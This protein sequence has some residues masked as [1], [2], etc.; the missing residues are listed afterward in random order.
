MVDVFDEVEEELRQERYNDLLKKWGPWVGGVA[1][2][3]VLGVGAYQFMEWSTK[4]R[5]DAA[6]DQYQAAAELYEAGNLV[7]AD[8]QFQALA[9]NAP[10]GYETLALMRRAEIALSQGDTEQAARLFGQAGELSPEPM[11]RDL[12]RYQAALAQFDSLSFD[13][14]AN[15]L[16]PLTEG[17]APVGLLAR[18]L[19]AAAALRDERWDEARQRYQL[20]SIALD[21]PEGMSQRVM[22][23]QSYINQ[24]A[25][26]AE[27][28]EMAAEP[29]TIAETPA[30]TTE[31][32]PAET[33]AEPAQQEED[34][35]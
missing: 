23:A 35:Q 16:E 6:S 32:A 7:Q 28:V 12:A 2:A 34:G 21:L 25:P 20:L 27:P 13:D 26:A 30:E 29:E 24:N 19:M 1:G 31:Q 22:Q 15:R 17:A 33:E 18:E 4:Q 3:I 5:A 9:E 8:S 11:I 14:L 10:R